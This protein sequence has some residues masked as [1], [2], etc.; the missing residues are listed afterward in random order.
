MGVVIV[1]VN[2]NAPNLAFV[3]GLGLFEGEFSDYEPRWCV[4]VCHATIPRICCSAMLMFRRRVRFLHAG[5]LWWEE[6]L[7]PQC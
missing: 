6:P 2:M 3:P 5:L 4:R 1:I 7:S